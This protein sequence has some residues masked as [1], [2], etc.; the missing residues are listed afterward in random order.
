LDGCDGEIARLKNMQSTLGNFIDAVLDRYADGFMLLGMFYYSLS[1]IGSK[2][3]FGIYWSPLIIIT[4]SI[5]AI[6]GNLMVSYSSAKSVVNFGYRYKGR[7]IAAGRGRD[8]RLFLLFIGG[9]MTYLHPIFAFFALFLIALQTNIIVIYRTILSWNC[10]TDTF[11]MINKIKAVIF[12][13]DGTIA[14]TMPFLTELAVELIT[15]KYDI[16]KEEAKRKYLETTGTDFANQIE[17][18]FLNHQNNQE[19]VTAFESKKLNGIFGHSIFPEVVHTLNYF[20]R[21]KIKIFV[22]SS[23][24]QYIITKYCK[25]NKID[26]LLDGFF[27]YKPGFGKDKQ[28]EFILERF[29]M[30]SN[31]V[32]FVGDSLTGFAL[33]EAKKINFVG[34]SRIFGKRE[35]Q[36][37]GALSVGCLKELTKLFAQSEKYFKSIEQVR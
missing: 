1:R 15:S 11:R 25:L 32:L 4:V 36:K 8:L 37:K 33:A 10:S 21:K 34:I 31:E 20:R 24:K 7:W 22:C 26:G 29:K 18:M 9:V 14:D 12:D 6:L 5:L 19:V 13:F 27:G 2:E 28:I 23:T 17:L 35:F 30:Q 3:T 16:S